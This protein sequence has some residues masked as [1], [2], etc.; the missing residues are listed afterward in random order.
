MRF[1]RFFQALRIPLSVALLAGVV[2]GCAAV[3][4]VMPRTAVINTSMA[5]YN[6]Y[7]TLLNIVRASQNEP[8]L[9]VAVTQGSPNLSLAANVAAPG[10]TLNPFHLVTT[11]IGGNSASAT[12][13]DSMQ[14][15]P[16][17]DPAS[18]QAM[19][20]PVDVATIGFFIKQG[21]SRELLFWLFI[22]HLREQTGPNTYS[23]YT[24]DPTNPKDVEKFGGKLDTLVL[25]GLTIEVERGAP[26]Y[27][28]NPASRICFETAEAKRV[29]R[30]IKPVPGEPVTPLA[31][32]K[33]ECGAWLLGQAADAGSSQGKGT[34]PGAS[35]KPPAIQKS[36]PPE[37][38]YALPPIAGQK[39]QFTTRSPYAVYQMMGRW[40]ENV[41]NESVVKG[42][43]LNTVEGDN[44]LVHIETNRTAGCFVSLSH[45][46]Q[47][48]CVPDEANL[49]KTIFSILHQVTGL[50][51]A[52]A[53][54]PGTLTVRALP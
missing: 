46:G 16:L 26:K 11:T 2:G 8:M 29:Q 21:Y 10:F 3:D 44:L 33:D 34:T 40:L 13:S 49:T 39:W 41:R 54:L 4:D 1:D 24:D 42:L 19:L 35:A 36:P 22:D 15:Q 25:R 32:R 50:N 12:A 23:E 51:I 38:W 53:Q 14:I 37:V 9:F 17:D 20:T 31:P 30:F 27:G 48:Y 18:W 7:S 47:N 52:H 6:N 45:N 28:Q 43:T 5:N